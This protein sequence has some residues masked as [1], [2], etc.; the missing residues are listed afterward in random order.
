MMRHNTAKWL[1]SLL[2]L[3]VLAAGCGVLHQKSTARK[4]E[5]ARVTSLVRQQLDARKFTVEIEF[6]SPL[7]G[8]G[9]SVVG[10]GYSL[11][12]E[13]DKI[14]SHL[15][16]Q[17]TAYAVPYGGGKVLNFEDEIDSYVV[18][19]TASDHRVI[20]ITTDND[21]DVVEFRLTVFDNGKADLQVNCHQRESIS[22]NGHLDV[23]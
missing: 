2:A 14:N 4:A 5:T 17:G 16:Y 21:E 11:T 6:M 19:S 3:V 13:G 23:E 12:V 8:P 18:E 1:G 22:Y 20:V 9:R 15:P 7:S 10:S